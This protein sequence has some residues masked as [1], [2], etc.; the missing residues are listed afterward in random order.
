M[1][2]MKV[3][4]MAENEKPVERLIKYGSECLSDAE[5]LAILLRTGTKDMNV[6]S[7]SQM[8]LNSHPVH[9]GLRGL[10]YRS[11]KEL[12]ELPGV[13]NVKASQ[14]LAIT[15]IA[16]RINSLEKEERVRFDSPDSV[17]DYFMEDVRFLTKERLYALFTASDGSLLGKVKLSEGSI[18]RSIVSARELFKEAVKCDATGMILI[19]NH[20]S[21]DPSPSEE[22][23]L[24]TKR[25][26]SLGLKF[27]IPLLD[28]IIIGDGIY[29][30][31]IEK[32]IIH[33]I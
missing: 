32:G 33:E 15:E 23:I 6:I 22:D 26:E 29:F 1:E 31:F 10:H 30:S 24:V 21:G 4:D 18:N 5:L 25:I 17:A 12:T 16:K 13:G 27:E 9:K 11:V 14:I 19:H 28:H 8:I 7:L 2:N 3:A 20:P